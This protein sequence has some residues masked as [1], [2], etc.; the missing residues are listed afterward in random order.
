MAFPVNCMAFVWHHSKKCPNPVLNK[1]WHKQLAL[2]ASHPVDGT[3]FSYARSVSPARL[4]RPRREP[5]EWSPYGQP[6][7]TRK[8][9]NMTSKSKENYREIRIRG[10]DPAAVFKIKSMAEERGM[11]VNAYMRSYIETLSVLDEVRSIEDKYSNL[12]LAIS[13]A[14]AANTKALQ[15]LAEELK[16]KGGGSSW[17]QK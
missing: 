12:V 13:E 5:L 10:V 6:T 17:P 14:I 15:E 1:N 2:P 16:A 4:R 3:C 11:S 9:K 8:E 7:K